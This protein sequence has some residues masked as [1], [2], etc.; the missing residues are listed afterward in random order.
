VF[1]MSRLDVDG[2]KGHAELL[3]AWPAVRS[4]VP[5][6][7]LVIAGGG[8]GL[9]RM[10]SAAA[11]VAGVDVAGFVP[12][13]DL[14]SYWNMTDVFAMPSRGEGFG[15]VYIEAMRRGIPVIASIHDAA[16]EVNVHGETGFNVA[17]DD[18]DEL[19]NQVVTLLQDRELAKRLGEQGRDRWRQK[20]TY[21]AFKSRF[22]PL[23][24]SWA[25]APPRRRPLRRDA[26]SALE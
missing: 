9:D 19:T 24:E 10:R 12:D 15:L 22:L 20:F 14:Q 8:P 7:K 25:G 18:I 4:V 2:Y 23:L 3:Q 16:Q 11:G 21:S 26:T 17:L 1:I 5:D 13:S 6:A